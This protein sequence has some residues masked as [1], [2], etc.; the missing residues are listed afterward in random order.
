M[1]R[2]TTLLAK[3]RD[4]SGAAMVEYSI[5]LGIVAVA[6][7]AAVI[8]VGGWAGTRWTTLQGLLPAGGS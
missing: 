7:I 1:T 4:D 2:L 6:V 8:A 3:L 5:L